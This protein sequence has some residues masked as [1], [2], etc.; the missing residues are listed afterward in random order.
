MEVCCYPWLW[1]WRFWLWTFPFVVR[2]MR[3]SKSSSAASFVILTVAC[4][5][6][7]RLGLV[8]LG[9]LRWC[10]V[11][12]HHLYV[13]DR[14]LYYMADDVFNC[15][16]QTTASSVHDRQHHYMTDNIITWQTTSLH[17]RQHHYMTDNIIAWQTSLH[18][19]QHHYMTDNIITWQTTS[20]HDR[21]HHYMTD[22]IITWQTTSLHDRQHH[23][24]T[25][26]IIICTWQIS[27]IHT[28]IFAHFDIKSRFSGLSDVVIFF[29][30]N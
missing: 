16:W 20:L 22:N 19:R 10:R 29:M 21:Q 2:R 25:D 27:L 17:D 5:G 13:Y 23:Y 28:S 30:N 12:A 18:D 11:L 4:L 7:C 1:T 24:M 6:F 14:P 9:W 15:T 26:T 8:R 3:W